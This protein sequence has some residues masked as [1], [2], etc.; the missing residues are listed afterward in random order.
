MALDKNGTRF[1]VYRVNYNVIP[2]CDAFPR[3]LSVSPHEICICVPLIM[4]I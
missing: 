4:S 2:Y 3:I 1:V